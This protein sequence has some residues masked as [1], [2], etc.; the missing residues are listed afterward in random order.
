LTHERD[1]AVL[2]G[3]G[4]PDPA[5]RN[6]AEWARE[7]V[8]GVRLTPAVITAKVRPAQ[9]V[10]LSLRCWLGSGQVRV[11]SRQSAYGT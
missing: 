4:E 6:F 9:G 10:A 8:A 11:G 3:P 7:H 5:A 1:V 2:A